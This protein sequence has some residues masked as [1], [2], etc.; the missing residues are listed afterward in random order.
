MRP[1]SLSFR[2]C[3]EMVA[4]AN[5]IP[6]LQ[7]MPKAGK[8][9][10]GAFSNVNYIQRIATTGGKAPATAPAS[11]TETVDVPY[12]AVYRFAKKN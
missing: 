7:L 3:S 1:A 4:C 2:R 11:A 9:P 6:W 8:V 10:T 12:T 5:S